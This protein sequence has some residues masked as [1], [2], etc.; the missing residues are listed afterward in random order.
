MIIH[1]H[2]LK[3]KPL[4]GLLLCAE[5]AG[6]CSAGYICSDIHIVLIPGQFG[7][8]MSDA[9]LCSTAYGPFISLHF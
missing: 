6:F 8:P 7:Q 2:G 4:C 1:S 9:W 3:V 5:R